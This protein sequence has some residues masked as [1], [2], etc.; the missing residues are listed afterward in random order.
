[1]V[2]FLQV[3]GA[4][5]FGAILGATLAWIAS[6]RA[7]KISTA[8]DMHREYF[9]TLVQSRESAVRFIQSHR[10]GGD[11]ADLWRS[12]AADEMESVWKI[13]YFYERLWAALKHRY[14][15]RNL[16]SDL[17]GDSFNYWYEECFEQQLLPVNDP[18][19]RHIADLRA[20]LLKLATRK[21]IDGWQDYRKV[22]QLDS[23][24]DTEVGP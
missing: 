5:A 21:Q 14:I 1:V 9:D 19:A 8:F 18:T 4:A 16:V 10:D 15:S 2:K 23:I 22:W 11:L 20:R 17:F 13:V 12:V 6:R 7:A 24:G 3:F